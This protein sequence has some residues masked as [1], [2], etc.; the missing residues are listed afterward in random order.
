MK[1][2]ILT[3]SIHLR[4]SQQNTRLARVYLLIWIS[5]KLFLRKIGQSP[6]LMSLE[7]FKNALTL[8]V[9]SDSLLTD[10]YQILKNSFGSQD[11]R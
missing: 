6:L 2:F 7:I 4:F 9:F 1:E 3:T 10:H 5:L 8:G 11:L